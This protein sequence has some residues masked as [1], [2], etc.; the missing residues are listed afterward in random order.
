MEIPYIVNARK[1][2]GLNNSKIAIWLFLASEVM[3]FGGLFSSYI[4]LRIFADYPWPERVLPV[5]PGL[6]NTFILI[7]SSVTVVFAWA[8]LKLRNWK[9]F[10]GYMGFTIVCAA[11]FMVLKGFEYSAKLHHQN[12]QYNDWTNVEGHLHPEKD[13][14]GGNKYVVEANEIN[15]DLG[16]YHGPYLDE[17]I[18]RIGDANVTAAKDIVI[19]VFEDDKLIQKPLI[20]AGEKISLEGE[21]EGSLRFLLAEAKESFIETRM[22]N[23][24]VKE[25]SLRQAWKNVKSN[26]GGRF[27]KVQDLTQY[28]QPKKDAANEENTRILESGDFGTIVTNSG[29][30]KV[31]VDNAEIKINPSWG[32]MSASKKGDTTAISLLDKTAILGVAGDSGMDIDVDAVDHRHLVMKARDRQ[33]S[34]EQ[35]DTMIEDWYAKLGDSEGAEQIRTYWSMH[36]KWRALW[37]DKL[38]ADYGLDDNGESN[39]VPI[40]IE[41]YRMTWKQMAAYKAIIKE[42]EEVTLENVTANTPGMI[43]GF[44]GA[45]HK[46]YHDS[47]PLLHVA[48][49]DIR[50]ESVFSP[51]MNNYYAIYFTITGLH[52][53]HV[54]G[55][56]LVLGY[57]L[58]FG[59]KMYLANPEWLANR[60]EVGGLFWHFVDLVWI[61]AFPIFYLM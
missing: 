59:R 24:Q 41:M 21:G 36:K 22:H 49:N 28:D 10:V 4:F 58:F 11:V 27:N 43:D 5:L 33:Y 13:G 45:N 42:G 35:I 38:T 2:T 25:S 40:D 3:L 6:V 61:F 56:A 53:L 44:T 17:I 32:R 48:R 16:S 23:E 50:F 1:D 9:G 60:V 26:E 57:Y 29:L 52:G 39:R 8:S 31:A 15:F 30:L 46:K 19:N 54:I 37:T 34:Q 7:A 12:I 55:G 51:K 47:F 20:K 14:H 18:A